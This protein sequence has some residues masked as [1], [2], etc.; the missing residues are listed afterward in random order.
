MAGL[1]G[2]MAMANGLSATALDRS[3]RATA[4]ITQLKNLGQDTG[5]LFFEGGEGKDGQDIPPIYPYVY[6]RSDYSP[7]KR[8]LRDSSQQ[9]AHP[10]R[11]PW[12]RR[13]DIVVTIKFIA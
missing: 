12:K 7:N 11:Y 6:I 3:D 13:F 9:V 4:K 10:A 8:K 5:P 1:V 2:T